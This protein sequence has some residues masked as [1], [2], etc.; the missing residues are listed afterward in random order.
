[1]SLTGMSDAR[2]LKSVSRGRG[3]RSWSGLRVIKRTAREM[4]CMASEQ[5]D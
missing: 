5:V 1:M 3:S 2:A 4:A